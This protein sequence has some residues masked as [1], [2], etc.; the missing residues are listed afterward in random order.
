MTKW[1]LPMRCAK[2]LNSSVCS[3][4]G[5]AKGGNALVEL[6]AAPGRSAGLDLQPARS[7]GSDSK[8]PIS[9]PLGQGKDY[10]EPPVAP[11]EGSAGGPIL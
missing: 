7:S 5:V 10:A 11:S 1:L 6:V 8:R 2:P 9:Q 4:P 3:P